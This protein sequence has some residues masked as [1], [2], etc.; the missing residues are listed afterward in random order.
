AETDR[1]VSIITYIEFIQGA[2]DK[3]QLTL[4]QSFFSDLNFRIIPLSPQT[5]KTAAELIE[6]FALS[7][8]MRLADALIAAAAIETGNILAT[9]NDKHYRQIPELQLNVIR[10]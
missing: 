6:K 9:G 3:P 2:K 10:P 4:N 7:H 8:S 1:C 5:G